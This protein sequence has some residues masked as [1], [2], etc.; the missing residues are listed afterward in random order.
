MTRF[1]KTKKVL[2]FNCSLSQKL[3]C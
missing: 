3:H 1:S 2:S